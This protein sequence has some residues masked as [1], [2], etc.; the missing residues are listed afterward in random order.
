MKSARLES[1][2][3]PTGES[4][5]SGSWA[6]RWISRTRSAAEADLL[7]QLVDRRLALELLGHLALDPHDPVHALDHVHRD[8]DGAGLVGDGPGD[9]LA[10]PPRGVGGEL[11]ALGVV[12]LLH[13]PHEAEVALLDEVEEQHP[14]PDVALGDGHDEA[15][16]GL[17]Q[18]ASADLA[19]VAHPLQPALAT[20]PRTAQRSQTACRSPAATPSSIRLASW[21]SPSAVSRFT[22]PISFRYIRTVS[23]DATAGV[24]AVGAGRSHGARPALGRDHFVLDLDRD[25]DH[26]DRRRRPAHGRR[27]P[28][29]APRRSRCGCRWPSRRCRLVHLDDAD[30]L[31]GEDDLDRLEHVVGEL[32]VLQDLHD[33]V[34]E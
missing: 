29:A 14:P 18:L 10:D 25:L 5:D 7:G 22:R 20:R 4:S 34:R 16:V 21:R 23:D 8:A 33:L 24:G 1:S 12:E 13:R 27:W 15:Q 31:A 28:P 6:M 19:V 11:E 3:S 2:S 30:A 32:D 17:D 26:G 9:R